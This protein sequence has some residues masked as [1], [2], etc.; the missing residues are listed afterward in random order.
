MAASGNAC[1]PISESGNLGIEA[2]EDFF[3]PAGRAAAD[4][5]FGAFGFE[6]H[7]NLDARDGGVLGGF[8][9]AVGQGGG[10]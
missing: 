9:A 10:R 4:G 5:H 8:H 6:H 1:T 2:R 7:V 3:I